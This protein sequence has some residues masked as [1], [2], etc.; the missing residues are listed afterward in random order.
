MIA[1]N[2]AVSRVNVFLLKHLHDA[3]GNKIKYE[4]FKDS[5]R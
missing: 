2:V 4:R 1:A 3:E 5:K